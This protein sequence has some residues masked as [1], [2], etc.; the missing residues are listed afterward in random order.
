MHPGRLIMGINVVLND[1]SENF[2]F[3]HK[4]VQSNLTELFFSDLM[5]IFFSGFPMS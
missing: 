1:I 5:N 3:D 2:Y 4:A